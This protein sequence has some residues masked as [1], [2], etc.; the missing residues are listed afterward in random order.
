MK[1]FLDHFRYQNVM[2]VC[3]HSGPVRRYIKDGSRPNQEWSRL[4]REFYF[5]IKRDRELNELFL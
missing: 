4:N 5:K 1:E 3:Y 2:Y